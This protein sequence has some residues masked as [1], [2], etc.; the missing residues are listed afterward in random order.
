MWDLEYVIYLNNLFLLKKFVNV[1]QDCTCRVWDL[2]YGTCVRNIL[3]HTD[4]VRDVGICFP[5]LSVDP[6][7]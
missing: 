6:T 2:E 4:A 3:G 1:W 5:P 7:P